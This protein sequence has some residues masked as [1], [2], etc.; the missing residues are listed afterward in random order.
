MGAGIVVEYQY[1]NDFFVIFRN[2]I[3][4][5]ILWWRNKSTKSNRRSKSSGNGS[6]VLKLNDDYD[7][8][9]SGTITQAI[10][11]EI[12]LLVLAILIRQI[13]QYFSFSLTCSKKCILSYIMPSWKFCNKKVKYLSATL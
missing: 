9:F 12:N 6:L 7:I 10:P 3:V 11:A 13:T 4:G 2:C 5:T 8:I 1:L